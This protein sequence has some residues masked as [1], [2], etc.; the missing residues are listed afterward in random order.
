MSAI[1]STRNGLF[2]RATATPVYKLVP[3]LVPLLISTPASHAMTGD[4]D[5]AINVKADKSEYDERRGIQTLSGNVEISQGSMSITAE[6]IEI[7]L[8][9]GDVHKITGSGNPVTFQQYTDERE[10][11]RGESNKIEYFTKTLQLTFSG[12]ANFERPGQKLTGHR[13]EYNLDNLTFKAT[14]N[15]SGGRV[16]ITLQPGKIKR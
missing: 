10:L 2:Y 7:E 6:K 16:N 11:L 1:K 8:V 3:L 12:N 5:K 4:R 15:D 13:I 9:A 14:G